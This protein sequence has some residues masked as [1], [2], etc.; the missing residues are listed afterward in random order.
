VQGE[1]K[2][3]ALS[4]RA[5]LPAHGADAILHSLQWFCALHEFVCDVI[6]NDVQKA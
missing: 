2:T 1:G 4:S 5:G 3:L 6:R